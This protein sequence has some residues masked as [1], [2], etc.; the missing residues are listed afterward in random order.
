MRTA[1]LLGAPLVMLVAGSY[2]AAAWWE[3]L[4]DAPAGLRP[5]NVYPSV[6]VVPFAGNDSQSMMT[7]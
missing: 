2:V 4:G 1:A 3:R 5:L 7:N 6:R